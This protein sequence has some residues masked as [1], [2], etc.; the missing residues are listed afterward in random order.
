MR[1]ASLSPLLLLA[2]CGGSDADIPEVR[3]GLA[4]DLAP[5][6]S[7][8]EL[9]QLVDGDT[10]FATD[11]YREV[12][13]EPGNLFMSPHSISIALAM[14]YAGAAGDTATQMASALHYT[15]PEPQLH[16]GFDALDLALASRADQAQGD[17][18]PFRLN[19]ANALFGQTGWPFQGSF[20]DTL[21]LYYGAGMRVLD[22]ESDPD[23]ARVTINGW[24]E[25]R[26]NDRIRDLLPAGSVDEDT[27]LVLVNAI[28]FSAAWATPFEAAET[29]DRAFRTAGGEQVMVPTLHQVTERGYG[30]G[31]GFRAAELPYDGDQLSMV[32][33]VPDDLAAFEAGLDPA[34]LAAV[35]A[36]LAPHELDLT[37]PKFHFDAPLG[38]EQHL[39]AL[40]MTDAFTDRADFSRMDGQRDLQIQ[41]V[42]HKG[43]VSI[44]EHGT[45]A[46]AATAVVVGDNS[47][48]G[49]ATLAV[50]RPFLFL[51]RDRPTG[52]IL[53]LGRVLDPR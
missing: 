6:V 29:A 39:V 4:R 49:P 13:D 20:L 35:F 42:L 50:D 15:L 8:E 9:G 27:R 21:A 51:I 31:A 30:E 3:S 44:D 34:S 11:L 41:D 18:I 28:Y 38:L 14:T 16:A 24:V 43:F 37:L 40:G 7:A 36:S 19:T 47:E 17:T 23:A 33:I 52:A 2:A 12:R 48:P 26:T 5:Q 22:F 45:E 1:L 25:D 53:F 10:A 32:V 46:A